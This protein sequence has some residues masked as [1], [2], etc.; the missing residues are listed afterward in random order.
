MHTHTDCRLPI[1]EF[2]FSGAELA[3]RVVEDF[4]TRDVFKIARDVGLKIKFARWH[5][6]TIGELD[7]RKKTITVNL[8]A[9]DAN[10]EEEK[11]IIAHEL[12]HYFFRSENSDFVF[13]DEEEAA[14]EFAEELLQLSMPLKEFVAY[15]KQ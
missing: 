2:R 1:A 14:H 12:G 9:V 11:V 6:V 3:R 5:P 15:K 4:K 7:V 10:K 8:N 13:T